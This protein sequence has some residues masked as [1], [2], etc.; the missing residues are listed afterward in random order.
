MRQGLAWVFLKH[1]IPVHRGNITPRKTTKPQKIPLQ[2]IV[3]QRY[4]I[5]EGSD[6]TGEEKRPCT[7][8]VALR[9]QPQ[10][11]DLCQRPT[12]G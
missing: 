11:R 7:F 4:R 6:K 2:S 9:A 3:T 10:E 12:Q 1:Y 8:V 5:K